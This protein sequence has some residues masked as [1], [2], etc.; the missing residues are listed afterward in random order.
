TV[1][2]GTGDDLISAS[3]YQGSAKL[4]ITAGDGNDTAF[5]G[6]GADSILGGKGDDYIDGR[7]AAD[8]LNGGDGNDSI[9]WNAGGGS[10]TV[11]GGAGVDSLVL[12]TTNIGE[13]FSILDFGGHAVVT[14]DIAAVTLDLDNVERIAFGGSGGGAD[15][16]F[17]S[18]VGTTEVK[19]VEIDLGLAIGGNDGE[20]DTVAI[21]A[22]AAGE[23]IAITGGAGA[24]TVKGLPMELRVTR[25]EAVDRLVVDALDGADTIDAS[26]FAGGIGLRLDGGAGADRFVFGATLG[27]DAEI[28]AFQSHSL[29]AEADLIVLNG[30][31]DASFADAVANQH[32]VQSGADVV[33]SDGTGAVVR[34]LNVSL[35]NLGAADFL[36]G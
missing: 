6:A 19:L 21:T 24:A 27:V 23:G 31:A 13:T 3:N 8:Q 30:F 11:D 18:G 20:L 29:S 32:I 9:V 15:R 35:A 4:V 22:G 36:F 28:V 7:F 25:G 26:A 16:F 33:V 10:D 2:T 17:I 34:L 14:R 12:N 1:D 5:G